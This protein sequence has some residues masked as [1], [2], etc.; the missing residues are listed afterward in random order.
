MTLYFSPV[1][2]ITITLR[3]AFL[4]IILYPPL[5]K[6]LI[7]FNFELNLGKTGGASFNQ[8]HSYIVFLLSCITNFMEFIHTRVLVNIVEQTMNKLA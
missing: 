7:A 6:F 1:L 3:K 4:Q 5:F 2:F 8:I